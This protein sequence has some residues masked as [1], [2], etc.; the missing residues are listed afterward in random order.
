[1]SGRGGGRL[2]DG[3]GEGL[4]DEDEGGRRHE[5]DLDVPAAGQQALQLGRLQTTLNSYKKKIKNLKQKYSFFLKS[6]LRLWP[7]FRFNGSLN[8]RWR[9]SDN[10]FFIF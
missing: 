2:P 8:Q 6:V 5:V 4:V 7:G 9:Q 1:M 10:I 3:E